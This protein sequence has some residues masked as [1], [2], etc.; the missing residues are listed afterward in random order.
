MYP[1][2]YTGFESLSDLAS[3]L[4]GGLFAGDADAPTPLAADAVLANLREELH[5]YDAAAAA[6]AAAADGGG[7]GGDR[8]G[9]T[10]FKSVPLLNETVAW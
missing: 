4:A 9:K 10:T 8:F 6:T 7:G 5:E 3:W 1:V 2:L